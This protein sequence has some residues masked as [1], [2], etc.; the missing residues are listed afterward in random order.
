V[1][2]SREKYESFL[3]QV[4]SSEK[5]WAIWCGETWA[6]SN[7][8]SGASTALFLVWPSRK[9]ALVSFKANRSKFPEA[10]VVDSI[11]LEKWLHLYTKDLLEHG[12]RP[13]ICPDE[14]LRGVIVDP[15]DLKRDLHNLMFKGEL[16]GAD[17]TRLKR[18]IESKK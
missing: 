16:Q 5:I 10:A 6:T 3:K 1:D 14:S 2:R 18:R 13:F 15:N 9:S 4:V 11:E 7:D 8:P 17:L 12:A